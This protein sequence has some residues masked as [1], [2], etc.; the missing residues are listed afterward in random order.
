MNCQKNYHDFLLVKG[1]TNRALES[2][3]VTVPTVLTNIALSYLVWVGGYFG[4]Y[5]L[6]GQ[7]GCAATFQ[8]PVHVYPFSGME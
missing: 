4:F 7:T 1:S 2:K 6:C 3:S 8:D 5:I